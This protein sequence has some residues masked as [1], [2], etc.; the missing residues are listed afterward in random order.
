MHTKAA[1]S[2]G[3]IFQWVVAWSSRYVAVRAIHIRQNT[4]MMWTV[5]WILATPSVTLIT[6]TL[7]LLY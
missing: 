1:Y 5:K 4:E 7:T 2:T 3:L 6:N